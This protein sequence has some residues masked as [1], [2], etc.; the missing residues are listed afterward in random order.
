VPA[1]ETDAPVIAID[2]P[3]GSGK[4]TIAREVAR[5]LGWHA[6]D[7]GALYRL[8]GLAAL[9]RGVSLDDG[10]GLARIAGTLDAR[11]EPGS[12]GEG[13]VLLDGRAVTGEL[14]SESAGQAAS[15]V[16]AI[17]AVR[18]ALIARQRAFR[19]PPGLVADG[20]DMGSNIFPDA[21]L[22]VFL[23]ASVEERARRRHNQLKQKGNDVS[24]PALSRDMAERDRRDSER[25]VAPLRACPDARTLDSTGMSISEVV[26]TVLQWAAEAYPELAH[27]SGPADAKR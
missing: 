16:A 3:G 25:S 14:R 23:T 21:R 1:S 26:A 7:S 20:R 13:A 10:A 5:R 11:F 18:Q 9:G 12:D 2:G 4:G 24:L 8:V 19:R 17:P 27:R 6:L 15:R 22:K